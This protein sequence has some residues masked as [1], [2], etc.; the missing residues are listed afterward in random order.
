MG[1]KMSSDTDPEQIGHEPP[2]PLGTSCPKAWA[3]PWGTETQ[4]P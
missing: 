4:I 3:N 2:P 1:S